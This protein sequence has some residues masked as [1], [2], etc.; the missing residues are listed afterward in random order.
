MHIVANTLSV[1]PSRGGVKTYL[2]N[3]LDELVQSDLGK[4]IT[5]LCSAKNKRLFDRHVHGRHHVRSKVLPLYGDHP[6]LRIFFDQVIVPLYCAQYDNAVLLSQAGVSSLLAP[7]PE[8]VV[9]QMP[10]S[11]QAIRDEVPPEAD[12]TTRWQRLYYDAMLPLTLRQAQQVVAVSEHLQRKIVSMYPWATSKVRTVHEGVDLSSFEPVDEQS[13]SSDSS[14]LLFVSTLFPYKRADQAIR[15]LAR[16]SE[17]CG[18]EIG[19]K[20]A[21][22]DPGG[23]R[24]HLA[25]VAQE[26]EV[27]NQ[28]DLLG[29]VPHSEMPELYRRARALLFPSMVETFGLPI[30]EAMACG[31]PVIASNRMSVP[32]IVGDAGLI[33][34]PENTSA[35]ATAICRVL[36][37]ASLHNELKEAGRQRAQSFTWKRAAH[38]VWEALQG[39][40]RE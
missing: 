30:L 35:L 38:G 37:D 24:Q 14:Y 16:A 21:G 26:V 36:S 27:E 23:Q 20:I 19:L 12:T 2:L 18:T 11:V 9:I 34:D 17:Q 6:T 7:L 5:L 32:E 4:Q 10:L 29:A 22:K 8:V 13:A 39:A 25:Q 33:V 40:H 3:I 15:A 31:T 1:T 28:V